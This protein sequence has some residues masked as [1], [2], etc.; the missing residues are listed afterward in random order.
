[1]FGRLT[2]VLHG[3]AALGQK[4]DPL[5]DASLEALGGHLAKAEAH[6]QTGLIAAGVAVAITQVAYPAT[7]QGL[8]G[9]VGTMAIRAYQGGKRPADLV[10][11][12]APLLVGVPR[13]KAPPKKAAKKA[14]A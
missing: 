4:V 10:K 7:F 3:L 5:D 9:L 11:L 14:D 6:V 8:R 2:D 12:L 13:K 1:M